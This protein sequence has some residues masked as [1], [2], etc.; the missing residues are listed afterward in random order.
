MDTPVLDCQ[1]SKLKLKLLRASVVIAEL[2]KEKNKL[3]NIIR[4]ILPHL[5]LTVHQDTTQLRGIPMGGPQQHGIPPEHDQHL[6]LPLKNPQHHGIP[7][8]TNQQSHTTVN[9][10]SSA[11]KPP[12]S[13][14]ASPLLVPDQ[15]AS[16]K[17]IQHTGQTVL[18][19]LLVVCVCVCVCV[20]V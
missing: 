16:H 9:A 11:A 7:L 8:E 3:S 19:W 13:P 12:P 10:H 14:L 17:T 4:I 1:V 5:N 15:N 2:V 18:E 20:C 6:K